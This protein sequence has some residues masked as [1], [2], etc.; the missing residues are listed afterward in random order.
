MSR[1]REYPF[2]HM[3]E[4]GNDSIGFY[5]KVKGVFIDGS[6]V[7]RWGIDRCTY[8]GMKQ[9]Q[10]VRYFD[11]LPGLKYEYLLLLGYNY[12]SSKENYPCS[13]SVE[14]KLENK[15]RYFKFRCSSLFVSNVEWMRSIKSCKELEYLNWNEIEK[16]RKGDA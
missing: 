2:F 15:H 8:T 11:K 7:F 3:L 13:A 12:D 4:V 5:F 10:Q 14:C 1:N 9:L 16:K 6:I